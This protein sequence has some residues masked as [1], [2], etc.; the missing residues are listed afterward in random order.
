MFRRCF[1]RSP[2]PIRSRST[3][4]LTLERLEPREMLTTFTVL[5]ANDTGNGSLRDAIEDAN[6]TPG[7]D[8]IVFAAAMSGESILIN[9]SLPQITDSVK[10]LNMNAQRVVING[11]D[12]AGV[13]P[14]DVGN[15]ATVTLKKLTILGGNADENFI[16][17][18][19]VL[20]AGELT[21]TNCIVTR[22]QSS[23]GAASGGGI[24]NLA[25][26][27]LTIKNSIISNNHSVEAGGGIRND[28]EMLLAATIVRD[29]LARLGGG[30]VNVT[31]TANATIKDSTIAGNVASF[32]GGGIA[33]R[34]SAS[35]TVERSTIH[36]N[37]AMR[38]G[39]GVD[40]ESGDVTFINTT[41]AYNLTDGGEGGGIALFNEAAATLV[42]CTVTLNADMSNL[43][44]SVGGIAKLGTGTLIVRNSV[45]A[46]NSAGPDSATD[47][48]L[49]ADLDEN[50]NNH[51][52]GGVFL[53][54]GP[55][56]DNG[57]RT[58]TML[59]MKGSP[60]IDAGSNAAAA[61]A[62]LTT[63][64]RGLDRVFGGT[65]DI[66]AVESQPH[67]PPVQLEDGGGQ[68]P[69]AALTSYKVTKKGDTPGVAGTLRDAIEQANSTPGADEITFGK[70]IKGKTILLQASLP[71]ITDDL[72]ITG[73]VTVDGQGTAGIRP[74]EIAATIDVTLTG[75]TITG[76][77]IDTVVN[78][79]KA[80]GGILNAGMLMLDGCVV[81]NNLTSGAAGSGAGAGIANLPGATLTLEFSTV[82]NNF[83]STSGSGGGIHNNDGVV[84]VTN[85]NVIG[86]RAV[87]NGGI[88]NIGA[89]SQVTIDDSTIAGNTASNSAG[90][91]GNFDG[92]MTVRQS[93]IYGNRSL[94]GGGVNVFSGTVSLLNCTIAYNVV[95]R[96]SA[97]STGFGGGVQ[98]TL[99]DL[100]IVNCTIVG[101]ADVVNDPQGSGGIGK[102][103]GTLS[104]SNTVVGGNL[105]SPQGAADDVDPLDLN[106]STNNFTSGEPRLGALR[107]NGGPTLTAAPLLGGVLVDAGSNVAAND[108]GLTSDQRGQT[109]IA[110]T[111]VDIGAVETQ[112]G[113]PLPLQHL[114]AAGPPTGGSA[115]G[116]ADQKPL[117]TS[118][119]DVDL[120]FAAA[121][122]DRGDQIKRHR[123]AVQA[124]FAGIG[125]QRL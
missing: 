10:I 20:N 99:G 35:L 71:Q 6:A 61:D 5:N 118:A 125:D 36:G 42:N 46:D 90:G 114:R 26:G 66:G 44:E 7:D 105:A 94:A 50:T 57:G 86:N 32:D 3:R 17:G 25:G 48:V 75:L 31:A 87:L 104:M 62:G 21:L 39:G 28:G 52:G 2:Q 84:I 54:L 95:G 110:G 97:S 27:T 111:T 79:M 40:V 85:S 30:I 76:G 59:P 4:T 45:V 51:F 55:L 107:N 106:L 11:Q 58:P 14:I 12:A 98:Q 68:K 18:G 22:N 101:N 74:F 64:Q 65:V 23:G 80:G 53:R 82:S 93:T 108:A 15:A 78:D 63:D 37:R 116:R 89:S 115:S 13:R 49:V 96:R 91:I 112:A 8:K 38:T 88:A 109:R 70:K 123:A 67:V 81:T 1:S 117:A 83:V 72:T 56:A 43:A 122:L 47:N 120:S 69:P 29:N 113:E 73:P 119:G 100:T 24:R 92:V 9:S 41:I 102:T 60:L 34:V 33:T 121:V 103:N 19:G 77:H 124:A 16:G